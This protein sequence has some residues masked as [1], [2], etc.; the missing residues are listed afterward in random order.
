MLEVAWSGRVDMD[1]TPLVG[2]SKN[3]LRPSQPHVDR[4]LDQMSAAW[5]PAERGKLAKDL[6]TALA[7]S[8][9]IAGITADSPQG[10]IHRRV[11]NVK[12]WDGW[13]DLSQ[14]RFAK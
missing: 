7:E 2:G 9:P 6:A 11:E 14:L 13:I 5:D 3:T 1:V 10:L 4:V 12:V 8:W